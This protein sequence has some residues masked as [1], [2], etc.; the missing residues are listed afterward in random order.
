MGDRWLLMGTSGSGKTYAMKYLDTIIS[1]M[2]P[3]ARHYVM[4]TKIDGG[5]FDNWPG[6]V[7]SDTCP[8]PPGRNQRYQTWR[9]VNIIPDEIEKWLY[10]VRHDPPAILVID[11]LN[12]LTYKKGQ[13]SKE[14]NTIQKTGRGLPVGCI[15]LT[16]EL[17]GI[18]PNAYKQ[19]THRLGF[20]LEG[21]YDSLIKQDMLKS[22]KGIQPT[23]K[24]G[25]H[26]QHID[27]RGVPRYFRD[28]QSFVGSK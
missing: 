27:G 7:Q 15:S 2:Y 10:Q 1:Q 18:P 8:P 14:Y 25:F 17:S 16:Q 21:R 19:A 6:L 22:E 28:I 26:Y 12:S 4:D 20:Y 24:Y 11:E 23:D 3:A 5:D 9:I 13:H